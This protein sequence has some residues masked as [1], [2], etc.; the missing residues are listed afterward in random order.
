MNTPF[1]TWILII[2]FVALILIIDLIEN[3]KKSSTK[4]HHQHLIEIASDREIFFLPGDPRPRKK[5]EDYDN[6]DIEGL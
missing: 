5:L 4:K 6:E 2:A 1:L 3:H